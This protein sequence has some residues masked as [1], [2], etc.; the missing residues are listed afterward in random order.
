MKNYVLLTL[1][2]FCGISEAT[3]N[4]HKPENQAELDR[5]LKENG[6][7]PVVVEFYADWCG[8]CKMFDGTLGEIADNNQDIA[9]IQLNVDKFQKHSQDFGV[10]GMPTT[11]LFEKGK[12]IKPEN[13]F[14]YSAKDSDGNGQEVD[15]I[16]GAD[17][18]KLESSIAVLKGKK[19]ANDIKLPAAPKTPEP[20]PLASLGGV[21][22]MIEQMVGPDLAKEL[23]NKVPGAMDKFMKSDKLNQIADKLADLVGEVVEEIV[24]HIE[25]S[26]DVQKKLTD[27]L[28]EAKKTQEDN[29]KKVEPLVK[30][31]NPGALPMASNANK[32]VTKVIDKAKN[33][34]AKKKPASKK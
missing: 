21:G 24:G 7:K 9:I 13:K 6:S 1:V 29:F 20:S 15:S 8:F 3:A 33:A 18:D 19:K 23:G 17:K 16:V 4:K 34:V 22:I 30:Q 31:M 11:F 25:L 2:L 27:K 5:V 14:K 12:E 28:T 26:D 10:Q 32:V